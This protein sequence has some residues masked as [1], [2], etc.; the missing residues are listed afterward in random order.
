MRASE[1]WAPILAD[2]PETLGDLRALHAYRFDAG[3]FS[4]LHVPTLLQVGSES[5]RSL[6]VTDALTAV[7]PEA[8]IEIFHG[9][10]H[11][12][13]TTAPKLYAH[14]TMQFLLRESPDVTSRA[15]TARL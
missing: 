9:Q 10:A 12:A 4:R 7:L 13:M 3:G 8:R 5:L 6:Y 15:R 2:A 11:E 1:L 14:A